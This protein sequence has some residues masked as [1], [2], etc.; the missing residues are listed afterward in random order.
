L[1]GNG[2]NVTYLLP[3]LGYGERNDDRMNIKRYGQG[4]REKGDKMTSA[5][6]I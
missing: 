1:L 4:L 6:T 3:Y 2:E 5:Q